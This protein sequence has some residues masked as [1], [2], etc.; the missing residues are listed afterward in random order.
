MS[1]NE[2]GTLAAG[3]REVRFMDVKRVLIVTYYF[4]PRPGVASLRLK[5]L[6]KY[7]PEFGW[8][9]VILTATLPEKPDPRFQV[10]QNVDRRKR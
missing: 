9:P 8:H 7:L 3:Q 2:S 5:G 4:S 10:I 1:T 6:A